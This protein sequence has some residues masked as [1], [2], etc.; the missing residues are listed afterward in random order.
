M[1]ALRRVIFAGVLLGMC[2][3]ACAQPAEVSRVLRRVDFEERRLGN[4]EDLPMHWTKVD[5]EH[6]PHYVKGILATDRARSGQYSFRFD[7]DGGSLIYRYDPAQLPVRVGAHYHVQTFVQTTPLPHARA[8]MSAYFTDIDKRPLVKTLVHSN[9]YATTGGR[10]QWH[11]LAIDL[12]ADDPQAAFLVVELELLQP[13]YYKP[14]TLGEHT[15][16][17]QDIRG[18]AWFDDISVAQVPDVILQTGRSGNIFRKGETPKLQVRINDRFMED[19]SAQL[20]IR[21]A[22]RRVVYQHTGAL[23][24]GRAETVGPG[25][26][27]LTLPLPQLPAGWYAAELIVQS[28]GEAL[29]REECD[30]IVL[31]DSGRTKPDP[32]FGIIATD[33][34]YDGWSELPGILPLLSA[35]RVKLAVWSKSGDIQQVD[36]ETF[37]LLLEKLQ[38]LNIT[39]TGCLLDL[40]PLL[41]EKVG[42][43]D[44]TSLLTAPTASWQPQLSFLIS[45][46][47]N[48]VDRWQLGADGSDAFVT[49]P[50]MRRVYDMVY[51]RFADLVQTPDVA[52]P[53]P[54]WYELS[55]K[56]PAA[57]A[58]SVSPAV[59]PSQ[60]PLYMQEIGPDAPAAGMATQASRTSIQSHTRLSLSLQLLDASKYGRDAQIQDLVQRVVYALAANAQRIDIP[61]PF[62]VERKGKQVIGRPREMLLILHTLLSTLSGT[63]YKGQVPIA[64]GVEAFLF[65]RSGQGILVLWDRGNTSGVRQL[66]LNLGKAP[67]RLDLWGNATPLLGSAMDQE[68]CRVNLELGPMPIFLIDIDGQLAQLRASVGI[69]R[70]LLESSFKPHTR[71]IHFT[72]PYPTAIAGSVKLHPPEGWIVNPPTMTFNL[73]PGETFDKE[74]TLQFPYNS[75]AGPKTIQADFIVQ[76]DR[77]STFT[78]PIT[79]HLGLSNVGMQTLALRDG[80][81]VVVQQIISNYGDKPIN[82]S[83]FAVYPGK[84]RMERLVIDLAPGKTTIKRYRFTNVPPGGQTKLRAGIQE[85]GG[86]R[87]LNNELEIQ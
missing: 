40:P 47:A 17:P 54:S 9:L 26:K 44:W 27:Q 34:P 7:L 84:S 56:L 31:A 61:L 87:I 53:W 41:Q 18:S 28:Q 77:N 8:R 43:S 63:T 85:I 23:D 14:S 10:D 20:L 59:L 13:V 1:R 4:V 58:L 66:A 36:P 81:D 11:P 24:M 16:F 60:L 51:A 19:L 71:R 39:T 6:L 78:V 73:N 15:L 52:M 42:G 49:N 72:N 70:P 62:T 75:Y 57:V 21:D 67:V 12:T 86:T 50:A 22:R 68:N 25:T 79:L 74:I 2:G 64:D 46:H 55:G 3:W 29:A 45:R 32:R 48:H 76:A 38:A 5:G 69:D 37:D 80:N 33:L 35:G 30:L 65:D 83:A 82:Y